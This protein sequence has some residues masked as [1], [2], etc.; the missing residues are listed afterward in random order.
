VQIG[1]I[2]LTRDFLD[3]ASEHAIA[4]VGL[5]IPLT[6]RMIQWLAA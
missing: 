3:H 4:E 6:G 5:G 2:G 1:C